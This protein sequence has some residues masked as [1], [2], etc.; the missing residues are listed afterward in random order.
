MCDQARTAKPP[1]LETLKKVLADPSKAADAMEE[2]DDLN[3]P[4]VR[5]QR[6]QTIEWSSWCRKYD[7]KRYT[8]DFGEAEPMTEDEFMHWAAETKRYSMEVAEEWWAEILE[9]AAERDNKGR[10]GVLR[11]WVSKS[12]KRQ[13]G[14]EKSATESV[15]QGSK[16]VKDDDGSIARELRNALVAPGRGTKRARDADSWLRGSTSL[17]AA[18]LATMLSDDASSRGGS[19]LSAREREK[20]NSKSALSNTVHESEAEAE[21]SDQEPGKAGG[22][23]RRSQSDRSLQHQR[24]RSCTASGMAKSALWSRPSKLPRRTST[25]SSTRPRLRWKQMARTRLTRRSCPT[26]SLGC[27]SISCGTWATT[28][29]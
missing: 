25:R 28:W 24:R 1:R 10:R 11:V 29:E 23:Q 17:T 7:T 6:K 14:A 27:G 21:E 26:F 2:F 3:P 12:E 19:S 4:G 16:A 15:R 13:S 9:S 5:H 22:V 20:V 8:N 18:T